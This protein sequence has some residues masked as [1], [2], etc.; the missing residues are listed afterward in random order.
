MPKIQFGNWFCSFRFITLTL[1]YRLLQKV[2]FAFDLIVK[3]KPST[4]STH[5]PFS[6]LYPELPLLAM[7]HV[8]QIGSNRI[9]SLLVQER[10]NKAADCVV[11]LMP[12]LEMRPSKLS[13]WHNVAGSEQRRTVAVVEEDNEENMEYMP[14]PRKGKARATNPS[15]QRH[16]KCTRLRV[17]EP[18]VQPRMSS[19]IHS[20]DG[21]SGNVHRRL[22]FTPVVNIDEDDDDD[23]E[24]A[25]SR[26]KRKKIAEEE[27][28]P[29]P[30]LMK[31]SIRTINFTKGESLPQCLLIPLLES[32]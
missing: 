16:A 12:R 14:H 26:T 30:F 4:L 8:P 22:F 20:V 32:I 28:S 27:L 10:N 25:I 31:S 2:T 9:H 17:P 5:F 18:D 19:P 13:Y 24:E 21:H 1:F 3:S 11:V 29:P 15:T 6:I 23:D 7:N